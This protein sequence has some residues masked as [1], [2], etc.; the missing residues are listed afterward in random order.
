MNNE[1]DSN[2]SMSE[3]ITNITE[4][5]IQDRSKRIEKERRVLA[6]LGYPE[7]ARRGFRPGMFRIMNAKPVFKFAEQIAAG[8]KKA[9]RET[10]NGTW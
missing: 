8:A 4:E 10:L 7:A 9:K 1:F 5:L 6:N 2:T 3:D